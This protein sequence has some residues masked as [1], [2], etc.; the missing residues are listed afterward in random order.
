MTD[1]FEDACP[2]CGAQGS[3]ECATPTG[4]DHLSRRRLIVRLMERDDF[5]RRAPI[6]T[7][8]RFWPG[9]REGEG[10]IAKTRT[11]AWLMTSAVVVSVEGY[12]GGIALS[13]VEV[14]G[15]TELEPEGRAEEAE[16]LLNEAMFGFHGLA[17]HDHT[18][19]A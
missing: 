17:A 11:P 5:N 15:S 8:V 4:R 7:T 13:H 1:R 14:L 16:R 18:D 19:G 9:A 3:E 12:P 2:S 6:G 10:R